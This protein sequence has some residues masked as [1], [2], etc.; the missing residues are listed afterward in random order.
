MQNKC[1]LVATYASR[2]RH[3]G[4][5]KTRLGNVDWLILMLHYRAKR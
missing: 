5:L 2:L 3:L 1:D 4:T